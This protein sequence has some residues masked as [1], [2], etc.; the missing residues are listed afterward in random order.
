MFFAPR[1][2]PQIAGVVFLEHGMH[3][4]QR[5]AGRA[6]HPRHV[7]REAGRAAA[8]AAADDDLQLDFTDPYGA[9]GSRGAG[10]E[11]DAACSNDASTTTSTGRCS[12]P[13]LALCALGVAMIYS[14]TAD[15]TRGIVAPVHHAA[16]RDRARPGR[17]GRSR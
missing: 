9:V 16:L 15:P 8:A 12:S 4:A 10:G 17:D 13:I 1:D 7:L 5:R 6:S 11:L 2:N 14:T 3:G